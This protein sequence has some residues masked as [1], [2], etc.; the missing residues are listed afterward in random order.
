MR[1]TK[2]LKT[3]RTE[4]IKLYQNSRHKKKRKEREQAEALWREIA[5]ERVKLKEEKTQK[6]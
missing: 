6:K 1:K 5:E 3:K 4:A 2:R